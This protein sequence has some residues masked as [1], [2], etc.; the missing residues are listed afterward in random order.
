MHFYVVIYKYTVMAKNIGTLG[1]YYQKKAVKNVSALIFYKK[2][3]KKK[4]N[5]KTLTFHWIIRIKNG[6]KYHYALIVILKYTFFDH[7]YQGCQ[8]FWP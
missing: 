4:K 6:G 7:I 8:Y 5:H 3:K 1:K 2:K